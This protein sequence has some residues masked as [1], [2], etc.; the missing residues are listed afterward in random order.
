V[1]FL[2][3][4]NLIFTGSD[5]RFYE[6]TKGEAQVAASASGL[7]VPES[8]KVA[9]LAEIEPIGLKLPVMVKPNW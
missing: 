5:L 6:I 9:E 1:K 8:H 4:Q 7:M 3:D 2:Q